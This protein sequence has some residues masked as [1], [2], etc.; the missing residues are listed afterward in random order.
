MEHLGDVMVIRRQPVFSAHDENDDIRLFDGDFDLCTDL[1]L[2]RL[3][4][5]L[6]PTGI[7]QSEI[8]GQPIPFGINPIPGYPRGIF[9]D[10]HA[11][12]DDTIEDRRFPDIGS[13]DD[14]YDSIDHFRS[15][16]FSFIF[17]LTI[18]STISTTSSMVIDEVSISIASSAF[19]N[20]E[21]TRCVSW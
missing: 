13:S 14:R 19:L 6:D 10:R 17:S 7:D 18:A 5:Q 16:S 21:W 8:L 2:K 15:P 9:D 1:G 12:T 4:H 3:I 11:F 20:G